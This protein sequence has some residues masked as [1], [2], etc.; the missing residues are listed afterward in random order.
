MTETPLHK[1]IVLFDGM[2]NLCNNFI[3]FAIKRDKYDMLRFTSLQSTMG[4]KLIAERHIDTSKTD[5]I[6]FI[7]PGI[8]YYTKAI[9]ALKIG[10]SFG[11]FW[12]IL[13]VFEWIPSF[14]TDSIYDFTAKHRYRWFGKKD[15]CMIPTAELN[16]K[17]LE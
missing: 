9:A 16:S 12:K 5:S 15:N 7:E 4:Q 2:C 6:I 17:F 13:C 8:A 11:G 10:Q 1:K 14:I 3:L